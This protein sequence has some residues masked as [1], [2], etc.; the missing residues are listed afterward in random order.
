MS[1]QAGP[2]TSMIVVLSEVETPGQLH[3]VLKR[4]FGFPHMYGMNWDAF[5]DA[6]TGLVELPDEIAFTGWARLAEKLP[7]DAA[8]MREILAGYL[9]EPFHS[10]KHITFA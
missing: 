3:L 4:S 1:E 10:H 6:I 2:G 5:W 9:A 7:R 8:I